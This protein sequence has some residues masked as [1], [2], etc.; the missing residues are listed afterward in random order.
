MRTLF[1]SLLFAIAFLLQ[2]LQSSTYDIQI[3]K[4]RMFKKVK[5]LQQIFEFFG[6]EM[7]EKAKVNIPQSGTFLKYDEQRATFIQN[8]KIGQ[9]KGVSSID[10]KKLEDCVRLDIGAEEPILVGLNDLIINHCEKD[11]RTDISRLGIVKSKNG[12]FIL[13][14]CFAVNEFQTQW[15][16]CFKVS[17]KDPYIFLTDCID[18]QNTYT[19]VWINGDFRKYYKFQLT[20][21]T[22]A[23]HEFHRINFIHRD[24]YDVWKWNTKVDTVL[25]AQEMFEDDPQNILKR[26]CSQE[27]ESSTPR[28]I[29]TKDIYNFIDTDADTDKL[30]NEVKKRANEI[31]LQGMLP[32]SLYSFIKKS[33]LHKKYQEFLEA[34]FQQQTNPY[35]ITEQSIQHFT[36]CEVQHQNF[37]LLQKD[38]DALNHEKKDKY[39]D[40]NTAQKDENSV[41]K[42]SL[43]F[44]FFED[45]SLS[46]IEK[47][48]EFQK[49][50]CNENLKHENLDYE[51]SHERESEIISIW[52]RFKRKY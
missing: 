16:R 25:S 42:E 43:S 14:R 8:L 13:R 31:Y 21:E 47:D 10:H 22:E 28:F 30:L 40:T 20:A 9:R 38:L 26:K 15:F 34:D 46:Q 6:K 19:N 5:G 37:L 44:I 27:T 3:A 45:E 39:S 52:N 35:W 4:I 1:F 12:Y 33:Q 2:I 23:N 24:Q 36:Y 11:G 18:R 7:D 50:L 17:K 48:L 29:E 49:L 51:K 32:S 41:L